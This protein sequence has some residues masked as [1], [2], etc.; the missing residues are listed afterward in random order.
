MKGEGRKKK[1][2]FLSFSDRPSS[3][4][5]PASVFPAR[6]PAE[7]ERHEATWLSWPHNP[8]TWS[9]SEEHT[10]ELQSQR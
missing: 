4:V 7:W 8:E 6:L 3:L 2:E 5:F 9:R 1:D 10:S